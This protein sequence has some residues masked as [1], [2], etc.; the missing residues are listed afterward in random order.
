M[1]ILDCSTEEKSRAGVKMLLRKPGTE[2]I[3]SHEM[4][5]H[6]EPCEMFL[7]LLGLDA[8]DTQRALEKIRA[9]ADR[10]KDGFAHTSSDE[11]LE[12]ERVADSKI[13]ASL[14]V[15]GLVFMGGEW[16]RV[17]AKNAYNIYYKVRAF[18]NQALSF[19]LNE[20]NFTKG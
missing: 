19:M 2:E 14:T 13:F 15:D 3:M 6:D 11:E 20:S 8:G 9:R 1:D 10:K 7:T 5:G 12:R 17:D 16:I 18:R 4:E